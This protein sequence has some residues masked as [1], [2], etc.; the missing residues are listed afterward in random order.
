MNN[1]Y[2]MDSIEYEIND[3]SERFCLACSEPL[4]KTS[5]LVCFECLELECDEYEKAVLNFNR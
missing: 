3:A 4:Y 5:M 2:Y 1:D